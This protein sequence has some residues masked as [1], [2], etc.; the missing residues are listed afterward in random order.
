M[1]YFI[2]TTKEKIL[3]GEVIISIQGTIQ[4]LTF[5]QKVSVLVGLNNYFEKEYGVEKVDLLDIQLI[6]TQKK[7]E[8]FKD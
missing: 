8:S 4:K 1:I 7:L 6:N 5:E 3:I 2:P